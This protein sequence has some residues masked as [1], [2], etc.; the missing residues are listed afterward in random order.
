MDYTAMKKD[1]LLSRVFDLEHKIEEQKHLASAVEAKDKEIIELK[2]Q[3]EGAKLEAREGSKNI[4]S[5]KDAE[6]SR[7]KTELEQKRPLANS[8][9]TLKKDLDKAIAIGNSY[10]NNFRSYLKA[11]QGALEMAIEL[12]TLLTEKIKGKE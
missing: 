8:A 3:L 11:Q 7:L 12:E 10:I 2:K 5:A 4:V 9:E 1:E 6:I